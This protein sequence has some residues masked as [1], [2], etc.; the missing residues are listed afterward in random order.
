MKTVTNKLTGEVK[1]YTEEEFQAEKNR[2]FV[3]W[4][5]SKKALD[6]AKENEMFLRKQVVDFAFDQTKVSGTENI[7]LGAGYKAK[8][9][10]KITFGFVKNE[11]GSIDRLS[12]NKALDMIETESAE[13][14]VVA[15][16]LVS[17]NPSL[18]VSEYNK[19]NSSQKSI[20][21]TVIVTKESAP[22]LSIVEPKSK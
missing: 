14:K 15:D 4:D 12:I 22:T 21:D 8:A 1:E 17:W 5:Q 19:L 10:K 16:R 3:A 20:I 13:G 18:S 2:L 11:Q 7:E 9:V 6:T